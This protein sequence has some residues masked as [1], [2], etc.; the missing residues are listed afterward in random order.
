MDFGCDRCYGDDAEQ[1]W[2]DSPLGIETVLM[3]SSHFS[4]QLRRCSDCGQQ[5]VWVFTEFVDW[6]GG[7]DP[8]Y[9]DV[10]P[11]TDDEAE[12]LRRQRPLDLVAIGKLGV[13][14]RCLRMNWPRDREHPRVFWATGEFL[15]QP[16]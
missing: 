7:N 6:S 2:N 1:V 5:F 8:Q 16:S 3:D 4:L 12:T 14:R 13:D 9:H 15:V 11:V 10:V